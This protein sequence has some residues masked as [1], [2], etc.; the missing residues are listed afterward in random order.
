MANAAGTMPSSA[1]TISISSGRNCAHAPASTASF[2]GRSC[3][4]PLPVD[5]RDV[6]HAAHHRHAEQR[7]EAHRRRDAEGNAAQVERRDAA[8]DR[9]RHGHQHQR[10]LQ[11]RAEGPVEQGEDDARW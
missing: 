10:G 6:Q 1:T 7:D 2:S 11:H 3:S 5:L 4:P 8:D 9:E